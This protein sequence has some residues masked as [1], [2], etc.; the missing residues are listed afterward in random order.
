MSEYVK[1]GHERTSKYISYKATR[2]RGLYRL[3]KQG[4]V[5]WNSMIDN[6]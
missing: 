6:W 5:N 2:V 4:V 3:W 1:N